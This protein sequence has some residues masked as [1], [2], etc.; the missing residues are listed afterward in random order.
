MNHGRS[1]EGISGIMTSS[2]HHYL[3][4]TVV[5][6]PRA[7]NLAPSSPSPS[8]TLPIACQTTPLPSCLVSSLPF[9]ALARSPFTLPLFPPCRPR[10]HHFRFSTCQQSPTPPPPATRPDHPSSNRHW[11]VAPPGRSC[12]L[13]RFP[14]RA[15]RPTSTKKLHW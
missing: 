4:L 7:P 3:P 2:C 6:P 9:N 8:H 11:P 5:S 13:G 15:S 1:R 10:V 14:L 12:N